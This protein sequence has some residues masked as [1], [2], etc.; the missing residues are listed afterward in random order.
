MAVIVVERMAWEGGITD[1]T[2][3]CVYACFPV[4][5]VKLV[6]LV[7]YAMGIYH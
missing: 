6:V 3:H 1:R 7:F 4:N 2:M 5:V